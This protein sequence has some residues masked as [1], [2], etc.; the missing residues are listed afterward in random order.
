MRLQY[1]VYIRGQTDAPVER[2]PPKFLVLQLSEF[3]NKKLSILLE[4][5]RQCRDDDRIFGSRNTAGPVTEIPSRIQLKKHRKGLI[6]EDRILLAGVSKPHFQSRTVP[7]WLGV[8][9]D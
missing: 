9:N 4:H 3:G 2:N 1:I 5:W 7:E 6:D 8:R